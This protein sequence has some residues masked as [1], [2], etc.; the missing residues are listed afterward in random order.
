MPVGD[1]INGS[2]TLETFVPKMGFT[3]QGLYSPTGGVPAVIYPA[4]E[5]DIGV[6]YGYFYDPTPITKED[7]T[8]FASDLLT[9]SGV[10]IVGVGEKVAPGLIPLSADADPVINFSLPPGETLLVRYFVVG[11]VDVGAV[12][13]GGLQAVGVSAYRLAGQVKD[14]GGQ[15]ISHARVLALDVESK[16]PVAMFFSD[17]DGNFAGDVSAGADNKAKL[18]GSGQYAVE[19]YKEGYFDPTA[20]WPVDPADITK[21]QKYGSL[22]GKNKAGHCDLSGGNEHIQCTLGQSGLVTVTARDENG[23]TVPARV[24]VVGFAQSPSHGLPRPDDPNFERDDH[25]IL[26]DIE[27]Q[28]QQYGYIDAFFLDKDGQLTNRGHARYAGGD[29][30]CLEPGNYEIFLMRGPEYSM[31]RQRI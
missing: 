15:P 17:S 4:M 22:A 8:I 23:K 20:T 2:G 19:V 7:G 29:S 12:R 16:K 6:S 27:F 13:S 14:S 18:F 5:T 1:W 31:H 10:S 30:F 11:N 21:A 24:A 9:V 28:Q 25:S 3:G 26:S